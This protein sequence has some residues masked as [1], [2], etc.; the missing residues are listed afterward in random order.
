MNRYAVKSWPE[1]SFL[2]RVLR[3]S[4]NG[5]SDGC[6]EDIIIIS[7]THNLSKYISIKDSKWKRINTEIVGEVGTRKYYDINLHFE[8]DDYIFDAAD[9]DSAKLIFE[10]GGV[11]YE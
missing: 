6:L 10:C 7:E 9:D 5:Y 2:F 3:I 1:G 4:T 8:D 11:K